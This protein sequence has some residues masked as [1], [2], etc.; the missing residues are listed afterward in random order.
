MTDRHEEVF[1]DDSWVGW[2][3]EQQ[4]KL[5]DS[6]DSVIDVG[7]GLQ[8]IL[9]QSGHDAM[10]AGLDSVIDVEAGLAAVL[11]P[12]PGPDKLEASTPARDLREP[13]SVEQLLGSVSPDLRIAM[14]GHPDVLQGYKILER[15]REIESQVGYTVDFAHRLADL[16]AYPNATDCDAMLGL[17]LKFTNHLQRLLEQY[18]HIADFTCSNR[19]DEMLNSIHNTLIF[20]AEVTNSVDQFIARARERE[21]A[22]RNK[23]IRAARARMHDS[24]F[25]EAVESA[26]RLANELRRAV[27]YMNGDVQHVASQCVQRVRWTLARELGRS[28]FPAITLE[29]LREFLDNFTTADLRSATLEG[30]NLGGVRWSAL[31]TR[32]PDAV[33]VEDLKA[34]SDEAP[35]GSGVY[36]IRSGTVTIRDLVE[37]V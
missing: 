35:P 20:A 8:E 13:G 12:V 19:G 2:L 34:R 29:E 9:L 17:S 10:V 27:L 36:V 33:D 1:D 26:R 7:A 11:P 6:L 5:L 14:R 16:L 28:S 22:R 3:D 15:L 30:V 32:W 31:H 18:S 21:A 4:S 25:D 23:R 24:A 37:H